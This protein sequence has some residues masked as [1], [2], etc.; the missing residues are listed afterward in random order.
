LAGL[1]LQG[2][3]AIGTPAAAAAKPPAG[4]VESTMNRLY[5]L[6]DMVA[7]S[8]ISVILT[9]ET[10]VGKEVM[11]KLIHNRSPRK[12]RPFF[13]LHCAAMPENLLESELFGFERGAFTGAT[14]A[15]PGLLEMADGGTLFLDEVTEMPLATQV[16]LLRVLETR[17]VMRLGALKPLEVD[18][19]FVCATN[20]DME[21]CVTRGSFRRDVYYRLNGIAITVPPLR[22]R[23]DEI[24]G[25]ARTFVEQVC[26]G[27]GRAPAP[28]APDALE[29]LARHDWPGN[30][31]E[32]KNVV[33]RAVVLAQGGTI[34]APD[35]MLPQVPEEGSRNHAYAVREEAAGPSAPT[36]PSP[37]DL[38]SDVE[39]LER[40]R[41]LDALE[42]S[43]GNQTKA[44]KLLGISRRML[45]NRLDDYGVPRPRKG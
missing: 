25:L 14:Q 21:E 12:N 44:A 35:V 16:K 2:R 6:T 39:A 17:E 18:L 33:E 40:R 34:H 5:R 27:M 29:R 8:R 30:I 19:R 42:K 7:D 22:N 41:I 31:R 45:L 26:A 11:A 37:A 4:A 10:G 3:D 28:I 43:A 38:H 20:R 32:L 1:I 15:K 13:A 36:P 9:G 24:A 23:K